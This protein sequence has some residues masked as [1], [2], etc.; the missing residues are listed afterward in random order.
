MLAEKFTFRKNEKLCLKKQINRLFS[1]GRWLRSPH[2]RFLYLEI[3]E[4]LPSQAQVMFSVPKKLHR[5]SVARNLL[6][7]RM[8]ESYRVQKNQ[9]YQ[10][11]TT[12]EKKVI[13]AFIYS[14]EDKVDFRTIDKEITN[15]LA[16]LN[17][18]INNQK[19]DHIL[20]IK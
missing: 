16:Q 13:M 8:R 18:R 20:S 9:L 6:K 3:Y 4:D 11:L 12:T 14:T 10:T 2:F 17:S 15:L 1:E 5:T 7:R 19:A